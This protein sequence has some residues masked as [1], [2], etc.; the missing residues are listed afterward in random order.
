MSA[1]QAH[2]IKLVADV[3]LL[4]GSKRN[5]QFNRETLA[6][7][8]PPPELVTSIFQNWAAGESRARIRATLPGETMRFAV[9]LTT[10]RHRSLSR[11]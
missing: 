7:S 9:T 1:L 11:E 2:G 4:P 5:P 3:R 8:W 10:W 6:K